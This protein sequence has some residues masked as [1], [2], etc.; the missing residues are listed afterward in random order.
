MA[1]KSLS[2]RYV[3]ARWPQCQ[4]VGVP[5]VD[6]YCLEENCPAE[7]E[8]PKMLDPLVDAVLDAAERVTT[9][10]KNPENRRLRE[11]FQN[12]QDRAVFAL[13]NALEDVENEALGL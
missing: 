1:A 10:P 7:H 5:G 9:C 2:E 11:I 4:T 8:R 12:K 3:A 13:I 6:D